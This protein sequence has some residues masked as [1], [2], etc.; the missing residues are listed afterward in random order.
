[1]DHTKLTVFQLGEKNKLQKSM[2][3]IMSTPCVC[4]FVHEQNSSK[5]VLFHSTFCDDGNVLYLYCSK[6]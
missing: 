4:T 1:M 5:R 6:W 3:N 2:Y